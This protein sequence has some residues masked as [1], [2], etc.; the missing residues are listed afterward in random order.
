MAA[1]TNVRGDRG[2]T[3]QRLMLQKIIISMVFN[4]I[5]VLWRE[6]PFTTKRHLLGRNQKRRRF[7][8]LCGFRVEF[9]SYIN[10]I[11]LALITQ[12]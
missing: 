1:R 12:I 6:G 5:G 2:Y 11:Q 8:D 9:A 7:L 10:T 3:L 4:V